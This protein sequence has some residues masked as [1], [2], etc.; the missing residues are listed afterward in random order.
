VKRVCPVHHV[1]RAW[2]LRPRHEAVQR[3]SLQNLTRTAANAAWGTEMKQAVTRKLFSYW[4]NLRAERAAP[5]RADIDPAAIRA[6]LRDT[7]I[8]EVDPGRNLP[9]R[10]AGARVSALFNREL[11]GQSFVELYREDDRECL[12]AIVESVLDDQRGADRT[13]TARDG[14]AA[15]AVAPSWQDPRAH[16]GIARPVGFRV[17]DGIDR[18]T[19]ARHHVA[20]HHSARGAASPCE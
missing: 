7:F 10:V 3:E 4:N 20:T 5:E 13:R 15:S 18:S 19:T 16:L 6:L 8:L 9:V 11:K 12:S 17:V 2:L 14:I 1:A